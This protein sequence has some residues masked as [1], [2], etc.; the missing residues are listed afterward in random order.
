MFL[1]LF[2]Q[3]R[4]ILLGEK[5][6]T[7]RFLGACREVGRS[8][9]LLETGSE[10]ILIEYGIK[11]KTPEEGG[12]PKYPRKVGTDLD[13][14]LLTHAHLDH[15]GFIPSLYHQGYKG[16]VYS[17]ATTFDLS[18]ILWKD[19]VKLA[20]LK[21]HTMHFFNSDLNRMKRFEHRVTYGQQFEIENCTVEVH[22]AGHIP[23]SA[24]LLI[25][26]GEKR[27]L[28]T[29]DIRTTD[30]QLLKGRIPNFRDVDV[31]IIE[32]TYSDRIHPPREEQERELA[33]RVRETLDMNGIVLL[34]A[35]A[36]GRSQEVLMILDK[37]NIDAPIYLDGM[38]IEATEIVL[39]YPEFLRDP[40]RLERMYSR[41]KKLRSNK[42][43]KKATEH[44]SVIV[45]TSGMLEG[46]PIAY[47]IERL[48]DRKD[49][50]IILTG[51]QVKGTVGEILLRTGRYKKENLNLK[52]NCF[53][54]KLDL[55]AHAGRD[56]L[57]DYVKTVDPEKVYVVHGENCEG[58]AA[59]LK[60]GLG[61]EAYA[62]KAGQL[63]EL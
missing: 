31:L 18:H 61:Y 9:V 62:P 41:V 40:K 39:K 46:G 8:G 1:K 48:Y 45:T 47:Y 23:G 52:V 43:R 15:S 16:Y 33:D 28:Y 38:A 36:V 34:P 29:G 53:Y 54:E 3:L 17:T 49:V 11:L 58:F 14:I 5:M 37:Y 12:E 13:G 59:E 4:S 6:N 21:N 25:D 50:S 2:K 42:E 63:F 32:S 44:S 57:F 26:T 7:L 20:R 60:D 30:T 51:Y 24:S 27:V 35:F 10:K 22:D 55:S 19:T 56:E